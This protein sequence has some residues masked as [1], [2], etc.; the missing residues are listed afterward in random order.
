VI[1]VL[2][3]GISIAS[4]FAQAVFQRTSLAV[5]DIAILF[6]ICVAAGALTQDFTKAIFGYIGA[7]I[8]GMTILFVL[9]IIPVLTGTVAPPGDQ[10]LIVLW[11]SI[12]VQ[13]TFP[14]TMLLLFAG[15]IIG[16]GLAEHYWY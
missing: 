1:L 11:I 12:L 5:Y 14:T 3:W 13:Q 7:M 10:F 4:V 9:A 15:S 16:A 6:V 2:L 8:L